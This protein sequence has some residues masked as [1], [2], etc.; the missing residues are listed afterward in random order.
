MIK[1]DEFEFCFDVE[2]QWLIIYYYYKELFIML[3]IF[4]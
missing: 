1:I 3:Y 4:K 2:I